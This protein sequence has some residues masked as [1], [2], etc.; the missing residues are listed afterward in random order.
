[1]G[2]LEE[3]GKAIGG[4][5]DAMRGSP[6]ALANILLNICFL[7]FLFYYV[8]RISTRAEAT[9]KELFVAQDN[10]YKQWS[11]IIK[12]TNT[13]TEKAMHCLLLEDA[14]KLLQLP[15]RSPIQEPQRPQAPRGDL[16]NDPPKPSPDDPRKPVHIDVPPPVEAEP[17]PAE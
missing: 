17:K 3:G 1:M 5:V 9:V 12:D 6:L 4:V 10:L 15:P 16:W 7:V 2:A 8:S 14:L 13:L 11:V